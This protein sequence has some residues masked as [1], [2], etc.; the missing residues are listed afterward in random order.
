M[1]LN[2][3]DDD[4][5]WNMSDC[6]G[7]EVDTEPQSMS[8]YHMAEAVCAVHE[9]AFEAAQQ[10]QQ[11][12]K[13]YDMVTNMCRACQ[14][15]SNSEEFLHA[16]RTI[17]SV[18]SDPAKFKDLCQLGLMYAFVAVLEYL[19]AVEKRHLDV[20]RSNRKLKLTAT[21]LKSICDLNCTFSRFA[22]AAKLTD[23]MAHLLCHS[24]LPYTV[25]STLCDV[26]S[27]CIRSRDPDL[28]FSLIGNRCVHGVVVHMKTETPYL[29]LLSDLLLQG[30]AC[31]FVLH[32]QTR[33][34]HVIGHLVCAVETAACVEVRHLSGKCLQLLLDF[35]LVRTTSHIHAMAPEFAQLLLH[36]LHVPNLMKTAMTLIQAALNIPKQP[37]EDLIKSTRRFR[38]AARMK[39]A[40]QW[41]ARF[42]GPELLATL[43]HAL[44]INRSTEL[45]DIGPVI[46]EQ[47]CGAVVF[48]A[49]ECQAAVDVLTQSIHI[50]VAGN[51]T[52][53]AKRA[54]M[55]VAYLIKN[56]RL[57]T[58]DGNASKLRVAIRHL[59]MLFG[60][61]FDH[62]C[63]VKQFITVRAVPETS[64]CSICANSYDSEEHIAVRTHCNHTFCKLCLDKWLTGNPFTTSCPVCRSAGVDIVKEIL[65]PKTAGSGF[66][67]GRHLRFS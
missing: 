39:T 61:K 62:Y 7:I 9:T 48:S 41:I 60:I 14:P 30:Q 1:A 37:F 53:G 47:L 49:N 67:A 64:E 58:Q 19:C 22:K 31:H 8:L 10:A 40:L 29:R 65:G 4:D 36:Q 54:L 50:A 18:S 45:H 63:R 12:L 23:S 25:S 20:K 6:L 17:C 21:C 2:N 66:F 33:A 16:L 57:S 26:I 51:N 34:V 32:D 52:S 27:T 46:V 59:A 13:H 15:A 42:G 3:N 44:S 28:L 5:V 24:D 56:G 35:D 43:M 55:A 11:T 38:P